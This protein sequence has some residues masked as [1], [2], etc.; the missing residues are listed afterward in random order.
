MG[1]KLNPEL[2]L[3]QQLLNQDYQQDRENYGKMQ[4]KYVIFFVMMHFDVFDAN[5]LL[6]TTIQFCIIPSQLV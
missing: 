2:V 4:L 3:E 5:Y 6:V 1:V